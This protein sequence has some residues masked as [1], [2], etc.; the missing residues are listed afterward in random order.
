MFDSNSK[1]IAAIGILLLLLSV[2]AFIFFIHTVNEKKAYYQEKLNEQGVLQAHE[3]SLKKLSETLDISKE[4]RE[5]LM[6]RI[7]EEDGVIDFLYLVES[8][9]KEQGVILKTES[10]T[11]APVN[12]TF[13]KL[14]IN[15]SVSGEYASVIQVL[16]LLE[17]IPY[18]SEIKKAT[19]G[20]DKDREGQSQGSW[21]G[22]FELSVTK[23]KKV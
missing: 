12:E 4:D 1:I 6:T 22:I 2:S 14:I 11:V 21:K 5:T 8:A 20:R 19:I 10:L 9:G 18:Q 15:L 23:F 3:E 13:E 17:Q 16:K 7:L